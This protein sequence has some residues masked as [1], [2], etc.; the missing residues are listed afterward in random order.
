MMGVSQN[1][2]RN[3]RRIASSSGNSKCQGPEAGQRWG[4]VKNPRR[5]AREGGDEVTGWQ[6]PVGQG[7]GLHKE[8]KQREAWWGYLSGAHVL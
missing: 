1:E 5:S 3:T 4:H 6:D 7:P 2:Y 8:E